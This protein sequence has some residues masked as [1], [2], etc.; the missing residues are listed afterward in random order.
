MNALLKIVSF[1][2]LV[3]TVGPAFLVFAGAMSWSTYTV[4]M[5]AGSIAW[6]VTAPL[7]MKGGGPIP[8]AGPSG[9]DDTT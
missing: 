1:L 8:A 2:G 3:L 5:F 7:W 9:P 4:L 6:F